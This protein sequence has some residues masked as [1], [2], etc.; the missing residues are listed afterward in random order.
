MG[1]GRSVRL[2]KRFDIIVS[3]GVVF[4]KLSQQTS[5]HVLS[6]LVILFFIVAVDA[7]RRNVAVLEASPEMVYDNGPKYGEMIRFSLLQTI[8]GLVRKDRLSNASC[9]TTEQRLNID[10]SIGEDSSRIPG[11]HNV[12]AA[13]SSQSSNSLDSSSHSPVPCSWTSK[14][15]F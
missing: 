3:Y 10:V 4:D 12:S 11:H 7:N 8:I 13:P 5:N 15:S 2:V 1:L 9:S 6:R 14:F